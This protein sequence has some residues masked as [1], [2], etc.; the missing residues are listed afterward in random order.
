VLHHRQQHAEKQEQ[1]IV[2]PAT[3]HHSRLEGF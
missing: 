3:A 2:T 1:M